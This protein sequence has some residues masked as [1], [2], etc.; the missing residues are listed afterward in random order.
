MSL[1]DLE[2][3]DGRAAY[4]RELRRVGLPLR[5]GGL[6]LIVLGAILAVMARTG[7][8][9]VD[10]RVMPFAYAGLALGWALVLAAIFIRTRHHRRRLA[11]GL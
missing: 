2:T 10:N 6:G 11:E 9:G 5:L 1:P 8:L 7:F 3:E 4:R